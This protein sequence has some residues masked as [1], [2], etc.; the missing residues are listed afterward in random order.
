MSDVLPARDMYFSLQAAV[1]YYKPR[2]KAAF[3]Q[4]DGKTQPCSPLGLHVE[5][6]LMETWAD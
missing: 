5:F 1:T 2:C 3:F 6:A 4:T